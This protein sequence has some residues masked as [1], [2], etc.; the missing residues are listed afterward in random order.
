MLTAAAA[1]EAQTGVSLA[2]PAPA[3]WDVS[4]EAGWLSSNKAALAAD[5]DDWYDEAAGGVSI[6]RYWTSHLKS[7]LRLGFS[8]QGRVH[9]E[10]RLVLPGESFPIFRLREHDFRKTTIGGGVSYQFFENQWFHPHLAAGLDLQRESHRDFAPEW[11]QPSR[12]LAGAVIAPESGGRTTVSW[13]VRP[14]IGT[15]FKWYVNERGFARGDVRVS[16]SSSGVS[17]VVW[18]AG[19]GV[20]L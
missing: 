15:G 6:G 18:T 5:W 1:G 19:V 7:E 12:N 13:G 10:E 20:D 4:G 3:V 16:F 9:Q 14:F 8:G 2:P 11:R 17:H